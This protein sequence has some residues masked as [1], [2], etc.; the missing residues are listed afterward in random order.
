MGYKDMIRHTLSLDQFTPAVGQGS[1]AIEVYS[2]LEMEKRNELNR[3]INHDL[4]HTR[5]IAERAFLRTLE[6]GC[7]G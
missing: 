3:L 5:L 6:G 4:T 2:N 7:P 1:M